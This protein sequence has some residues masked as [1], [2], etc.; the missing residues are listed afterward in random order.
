MVLLNS[1]TFQEEWSPV[2]TFLQH[3]H[4]T[5]KRER[6]QF[7]YKTCEWKHASLR[8]STSRDLLSPTAITQF[9]LK[10]C[11]T[12]SHVCSFSV[13]D[14]SELNASWHLNTQLFHKILFHM[15]TKSWRRGVA[16]ECQTCDQKLVDSSLGRAPRRKNSGQVSH[17]YVPLSPSSTSWYWPKGGDAWR[18]G[19]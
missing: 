6:Y 15:S 11:L 12:Q 10:K 17:T 9:T 3:L 5:T 13:C 2:S 4:F 7:S 14:N 18:L 8:Q 19:R 16:V 1:M